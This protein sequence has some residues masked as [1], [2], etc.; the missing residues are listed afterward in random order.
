MIK[1][2]DL[3]IMTVI[4]VTSYIAVPIAILKFYK[5]ED[6]AKLALFIILTTAFLSFASNLLY[7]YIRG[8]YIFIPLLSIIVSGFLLALFNNTAT[9]L[10]LIISV[11]SILGYFLGNLFTRSD[12]EV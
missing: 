10:I 4:F 2:K 7:A 9:M 1:I 8:K 5:T 12:K 3:F 11:L 6:G